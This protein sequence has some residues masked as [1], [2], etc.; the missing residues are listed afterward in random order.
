VLGF[1]LLISGASPGWGCEG[2]NEIEAVFCRLKGKG[3]NL[4]SMDDFRRNTPRMQYLLL[5]RPAQQVG[6][7]LPKPTS[8]VK[9][10]SVVLPASSDRPKPKPK[11]ILKSQSVAET[12]TSMSFSKNIGIASSTSIHAFTNKTAT[13]PFERCVLNGRT[14]DCTQQR[15]TLV[16]NRFNHELGADA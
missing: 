1:L 8:V 12:A 5:K 11:K 6:M 3:V 7:A 14:I 10:A 4:P 16:E 13:Q 2:N 15:F 9:S